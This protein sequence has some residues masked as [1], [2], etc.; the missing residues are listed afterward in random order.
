MAHG[1]NANLVHK[2][3]ARA[4]KRQDTAMTAPDLSLVP[5]GLQA[6]TLTSEVTEL[7][8]KLRRGPVTA[9]VSWPMSSADECAAWLREVLR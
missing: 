3:R 6:T 4:A 7:R 9:T 1:V 5:V 8:I 2:W